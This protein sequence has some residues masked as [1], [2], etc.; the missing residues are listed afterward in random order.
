LFA[1]EIGERLF[2]RKKQTKN[3][4]RYDKERNQSAVNFAHRNEVRVRFHLWERKKVN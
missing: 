1:L 4:S 2:E 3:I